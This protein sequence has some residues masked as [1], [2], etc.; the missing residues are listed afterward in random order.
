LFAVSGPDRDLGAGAF[1][2]RAGDEEAQAHAALAGGEGGGEGGRG[3]GAA[4]AGG[5]RGG[6]GLGGQGAA[7]LGLGAAGHIGLAQ[8]RQNLGGEAGAVVQDVDLDPAGVDHGGQPHL[9]GGEVGGVLDQGG[10]AVDDLGQAADPRHGVS[11]RRLDGDLEVQVEA[12]VRLGHLFQQGLQ[13]DVGEQGVALFGLG[14]Q[15]LENGPAAFRLLQ[16]QGGVLGGR[17]V[18]G[19]VAQHLLGDDLDGGQ[20]RAQFM[21]GGGGQAAQGRQSL[22][23]LQ[24]VLG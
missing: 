20:R 7:G 4:A 1:Q 15:L 3:R 12:P 23:A 19:S 21:G 14:R 6:G 13:V 18:G 9:A 17:T 11:G 22:L 5:A 2:Q 8:A 10:Q 16:D 24:N